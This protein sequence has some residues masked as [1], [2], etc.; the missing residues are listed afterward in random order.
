[1]L[2]GDGIGQAPNL[3]VESGSGSLANLMSDMEFYALG[4]HLASNRCQLP[5]GRI[6][7]SPDDIQD[8]VI[9]QWLQAFHPECRDTLSEST[10]GIKLKRSDKTSVLS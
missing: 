3:V 9:E 6:S 5:S 4:C 1:M 10:N 7:D 2:A 8:L